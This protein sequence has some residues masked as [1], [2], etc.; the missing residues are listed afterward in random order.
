MRMKKEIQI[1]F[2]K[3]RDRIYLDMFPHYTVVAEVLLDESGEDTAN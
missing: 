3:L 2:L 1:P